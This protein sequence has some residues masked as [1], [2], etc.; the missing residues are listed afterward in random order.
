MIKNISFIFFFLINTAVFSQTQQNIIKNSGTE[1]KP[2]SEIDS[3]RFD[4][5][6]NKMEI[7]LNNGNIDDHNLP[8]INYINFSGELVGEIASLNCN[9]ANINGT[10]YAGV[11]ANDI[12]LEIPYTGGNGGAF[13]SQAVNSMG[14]TGLT[15]IL[16]T[17]NFAE[18][19]GTLNFT[20]SGLPNNYGYANFEF[21]T[22]GQ[23]CTL[24]V[25]INANTNDTVFCN[26]LPTEIIDVINPVTGKIWMD[27]NLGAT[28]VATS[29]TDELSYGDLYQWGRGK[30][31]HQ[32]RN[33]NNT[34]TISSID[35]PGH[36]DFIVNNTTSPYD[37]RSP[38]NN[39]LWQGVNGINNPCPGG[40]RLPT[41]NE[42]NSEIQSWSSADEVGAFTSIL[43][44]P[45]SGGRSASNGSIDNVGSF[46][47]YWSSSIIDYLSR[48]L[49]FYT[50]GADAPSF[51]RAFG[52]SVR[53]IKDM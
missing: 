10:L 39:N 5:N 6:L 37:W 32:C 47:Y 48:G 9:E 33:S 53:C 2:I 42:I 15:A 36:S 51:A 29:S 16:D 8:D 43:K 25:F 38:L 23:N 17:G 40:Y 12:T 20:I 1:S 30:D 22:G 52:F 35:Q 4:V 28:Q 13:A 44:L 34:A 24:S 18:G 14:V 11:P 41:V 49:R 26:G 7:V 46:G 31:G 3:I 50:Y 21:F 27:R 45:A 19:D